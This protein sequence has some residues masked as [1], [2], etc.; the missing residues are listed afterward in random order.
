[1]RSKTCSSTSPGETW[2]GWVKH[3]QIVI[4]LSFVPNWRSSPSIVYVIHCVEVCMY[5]MH[6]VEVC[7]I[8]TAYLALHVQYWA[9]YFRWIILFIQL[10]TY[11]YLCAL[12]CDITSLFISIN[13]SYLDFVLC[14]YYYFLSA[15]FNLNITSFIHH[16][17]WN[18]V[19]R[20]YLSARHSHISLSCSSV[21]VTCH[22]T[23]S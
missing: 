22:V 12:L 11:I 15:F 7:V 14:F 8:L 5:A 6:C 13:C 18:A 4:Q 10:C 20:K 17:S 16:F 2:F 23:V 21:L 19:W 1:M 9:L 3:L